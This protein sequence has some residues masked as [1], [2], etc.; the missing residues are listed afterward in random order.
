MARIHPTAIVDSKAD[1]A[2][3][4][5]IGA[6]AIIKGAVVLGAGTIIHEHTHVHGH[7]V[8]GRRCKMGPG[9]YI[10]L[11]PQDLKYKGVPSSLVIG[12]DVTIRETATIHRS[13]STGIENAT[14][15][16]D[17]CFIMAAAHVAHDCVLGDGVIIANAALLGGHVTLGTRCIIGGGATIHQFVRVGRLAILAGNEPISHD[18]PPFA[19]ARYRS[20]K[21]YNAIGC[22][23][24]GMSQETIFA[25]R[26]AFRALHHHRVLS[27]AIAAMKRSVP[28]TAEVRE[29]IT[30][31][32][33][34]RRG[35]VPS[36][37]QR[38][39]HG[40]EDE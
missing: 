13:T 24:S 28:D 31:L 27:D 16:G 21:G 18:I 12:D 22:K 26:S 29:L 17:K 32:T 20:L 9:A 38:V 3:D 35:I 34:T 14:R 36:H 1:L 5:E 11:D 6:F 25:I 7:T 19:A 4:V 23:R 2:E 30:F 39:Q 40:D 8:M 37:R 15:I 33:T 10:G